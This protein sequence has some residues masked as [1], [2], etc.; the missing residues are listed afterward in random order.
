MNTRAV[1]R[2]LAICAIT[3]AALVGAGGAAAYYGGLRINTTESMPVGLWLVTTGGVIQRGQVVSV[4]PVP[5][6]VMDMAKERGYVPPGV[7]PGRYEPLIKPVAAVAGDLVMVSTEGVSVNGVAVPN[8][9]QALADG[10]GR[11]MPRIAPGEYP[12]TSGSVWVLSSYNAASFDSRYFGPLPV[13][14][15]E[16]TARPLFTKGAL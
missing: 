6:E 2:S 3:A 14:N 7:C 1:G 4:C 12:V 5:G 9:Q 10:A 11:Q 8:T 15:I 16:G 13:S